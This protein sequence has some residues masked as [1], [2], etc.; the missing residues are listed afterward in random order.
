M[1]L[2][3]SFLRRMVLPHL[4]CGVV[5]FLNSTLLI[6]WPTHHPQCPTP[7]IPSESPGC[8]QSILKVPGV[9]ESWSAQPESI[10][11]RR[12]SMQSIPRG[13]EVR[14]SRVSR[15]TGVRSSRVHFHAV[16][17]PCPGKILYLYGLPWLSV[18]R[19]AA[20]LCLTVPSV[21]LGIPPLQGDGR[22]WKA[23]K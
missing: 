9:L 5:R 13:P 21:N 11:S 1:V 18:L 2:A 3:A 20:A 12:N 22:L 17:V 6:A 14:S 7:S 8:A 15:S 23:G 19:K 16:P 4:P 10:S